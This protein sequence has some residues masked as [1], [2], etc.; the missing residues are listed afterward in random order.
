MSIWQLQR[1][2]EPEQMDAPEEV[3]S[4]SSAAAEKHLDAIDNTFVE[5][6]LHLLPLTNTIA[7]GWALDIGTGPA[8]IP[9]K[10]LT[11]VPTLRCIGIDRSLNMLACARS[12][13]VAAGVSDRLTLVCSEGRSLPFADGAFSVVLCNS[14][15]HHANEPVALLREMFRVASP[16]AAILLRDLRRPSRPLLGWHLW[17][18]GRHYRGEMRRLFD[19]SVRAAYTPEELG[20]MLSQ[21]GWHGG[22]LFRF[23]GAHLGVERRGVP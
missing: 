3:S 12:S 6:V 2:P 7:P 9:I 1:I 22:A 20:T 19:A 8:Q 14:V 10:I 5:H 13:A 23:R 18:H 11:R 16:Q 17:R 4:Y 15:L 21:A